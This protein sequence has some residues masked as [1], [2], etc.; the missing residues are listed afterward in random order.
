MDNGINNK[1]ENECKFYRDFNL[2]NKSYKHLTLQK[3]IF[4]ILHLNIRSLSCKIDELGE[5]LDEFE[6]TFDVVAI[7]ESWLSDDRMNEVLLD[8]YSYYGKNRKN[9]QGG[10]VGLFVSDKL[11]IKI[12]YD[13]NDKLSDKFE[14]Y[15]IEIIN[16]KN[17]K[18]IIVLV[19]YR[20]PTYSIKIFNE[21]MDEI[22][23]SLNNKNKHI[24][25]V[26][27]FNVNLI[28]ENC[29]LTQ[30]ME[31]HGMEKLINIPTRI[32]TTKKSTIDNI[33]IN[34]KNNLELCGVLNCDLSDHLPIFASIRLRDRSNHNNI[35]APPLKKFS[36]STTR[37]NKL[38]DMLNET[39]WNE[40]YSCMDAELAWSKFI[41]LF[42]IAFSNCCEITNRNKIIK[43]IKKKPW[44]TKEI[45]KLFKSK[46]N[47]YKKYLTNP[48]EK[49]YS[50]F[51]NLNVICK[52]IKTNAKKHYLHNLLENNKHDAKTTWS[53]V[54][55]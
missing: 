46:K 37:I 35:I 14:T 12:R 53:V 3:H 28:D 9:K 48:S 10:G 33:F 24:I 29:T 17:N 2:L 49:N 19:A 4:N 18:N 55:N 40:V 25:C 8:G 11:N 32:S 41:K 47:C 15:V 45:K 20:P 54:S 39:D 23:T 16:D 34:C 50:R 51:K 30:N 42:Q 38:C 44:I 21:T 5:F 1:E 13:I 27:D 7:S 52:K 22:L 43:M 31:S 6:F 36:F 26:G